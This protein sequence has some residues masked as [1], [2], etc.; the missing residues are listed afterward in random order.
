MHRLISLLIF[1]LS[2]C[3]AFSALPCAVKSGP[4]TAALV[5]LYTSEGCSSCPSADRRLSQ[6]P[7]RKF[8]ADKIVPIALHV[9]YWDYIGWRDPYAKA[10]FS[11]R[12]HWLVKVNNQTTVY[13]PHFFVSGRE[14]GN[15][16]SDLVSE[17]RRINRQPARADVGLR[18]NS[19]KPGILSLDVQASS[20]DVF[21]PLGLF[22]AVTESKLVSQVRSGENKGATLDHDY[23]VRE[24]IGPI[25]LVN[26]AVT[27][28]REIPLGTG[29]NSAEIGAV[30]FVQNTSTGE[31]LQAVSADHC[32]N[33][34]VK[35]S[36]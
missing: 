34:Q 9:D 13:T 22:V 25:A 36:N 31:V 27:A 6:L 14:L 32:A 15:G 21:A 29:W 4:M 16:S 24:W 20:T 8:S 2:T 33:V 10:A 3:E 18:T 35:Q 23:V 1:V 28:H 30:G 26:G 17:T 19:I 12:Q 7:D 11:E 5:E